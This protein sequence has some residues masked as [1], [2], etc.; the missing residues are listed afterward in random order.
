MAG[1]KRANGHE[2][3]ILEEVAEISR[4]PLETVRYWCRKGKLESVRPGRRRLVRRADLD[5][6]LSAAERVEVAR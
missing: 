2:F 5:R 3:L 4:T 1:G 6:F